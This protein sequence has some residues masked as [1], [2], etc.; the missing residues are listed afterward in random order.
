M[1][2]ILWGYEYG[3]GYGCGL[4]SCKMVGMVATK[5]TVR[6]ALAGKSFLDPINCISCVLLNNSLIFER[7]LFHDNVLYC[8]YWVNF[9]VVVLRKDINHVI[10]L[11]RQ[12]D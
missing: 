5:T 1:D 8:E 9:C 10:P 7:P 6:L 12:A 4:L 3:Y 2:C 11:H